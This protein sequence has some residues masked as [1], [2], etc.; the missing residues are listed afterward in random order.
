MG[1][2]PNFIK[3]SPILRALEK[4]RTALEDRFGS[5]EARLVHTGQ[6]YDDA[7]SKI[8]FEQ[9]D[10]PQPDVNLGVTADSDPMTIANTMPAF[11]KELKSN[12]ADL[13]IV[14]GDVNA[15]TACAQVAAY[16]GVPVAHVEAGLRSFDRTMPEELNRIVT[17]HL[18]SLLFASCDDGVENLLREGADRDSIKLVGNVMIDTLVHTLLQIKKL[19]DNL[20]MPRGDFGLATLHRPSNVD[21]PSILENILNAMVRISER[22]PI[23]LPLHPRALSRIREANLSHL[24]SR[25]QPSQLDRISTEFTV[26]ITQPLG[27]LEFQALMSAAAVVLTDSG[28]LQEETTYLRI[29]CVT[30]RNNTERPITIR[31]GSNQLAG[32]DPDAIEAAVGAVIEGRFQPKDPPSL[33][34]GRAA[35]RIVE[36][37]IALSDSWF[38]SRY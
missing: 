28:G 20:S 22:L 19:R 11:E 34:D 29:P 36:E 7:M 6:H 26:W 2:R 4:K 32:T 27:Y 23:I 15:T 30:I 18:S 16:Y 13:V 25:V 1:T 17:D 35:E 31:Q 9:L 21:D 14:V 8:F 5:F 24:V 10:I 38:T 37:I 33:W 3:I 12:E